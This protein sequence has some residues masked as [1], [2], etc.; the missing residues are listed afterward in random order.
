MNVSLGGKH[1]L[2]CG[3]SAGIGRACAVELAALGASVT[4]AARRAEVVRD[5]VAGLPTT[6]G[7][8]HE[9]LVVDLSQP[10]TAS[11]AV[12]DRLRAGLSFHILVNNTG[13]PP[14]GTALANSAEEYLG[15]FTS[16]LL[17]AQAL[18]RACLPGMRR[19][20]YGRIINILSTSVKAPIPTL[21]I[22]NTVRAGVAAW[23]KSLS[24]ELGPDQITVNNVLPGFTDTDRLKDLQTTWAGHQGISQDE[25]RTRQLGTIPMRRFG[26]AGE[27]AA[28]V[29]FL[30]SPAASYVSGINLPV[31]GGRTPVL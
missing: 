10:A 5:V 27:I 11:T 13:G 21:A 18:V 3:A 14:E 25:L 15:A 6:H 16:H 8:R 19:D 23:A 22:S 30:A 7:Q 1:A 4:V 2:V 9:A 12:E 31:D 28:A 24:I 29:A 17:T 26:E 20:A